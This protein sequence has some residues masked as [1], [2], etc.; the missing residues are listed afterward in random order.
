L[1]YEIDPGASCFALL[2]LTLWMLGYP[3]QALA[4]CRQAMLLIDELDNPATSALV[5]NYLSWYHWMRGEAE[6]GLACAERSLTLCD[7]HGFTQLLRGALAGK[8][9]ALADLGEIEEGIAL[10]EQGSEIWQ[11]TGARNLVPILLFMLANACAKGG[12]EERALSLL[13][14]A[15]AEMVERDERRA[16]SELLRLKADLLHRRGAAPAQVEA[17]YQQALE[18]ARIQQ[19][20]MLE[21]RAAIDLSRFWQAQGRCAEA[22]QLLADVYGW[23]T[24]GFDT[25]DLQEARMLLNRLS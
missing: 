6:D 10:L 16:E 25:P 14:D 11:A 3:D 12:Q 8:G 15:L 7:R 18:M 9:N 22:R 17:I 19:A 13:E 21:L 2:V 23:F 20:K 1:Y 4:R 24:E 5:L